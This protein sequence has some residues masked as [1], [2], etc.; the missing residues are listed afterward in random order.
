MKILLN[1]EKYINEAYGVFC[2]FVNQ[3]E[4]LYLPITKRAFESALKRQDSLFLAAEENGELIGF[5]L[6][7]VAEKGIYLTLIIVKHNHRNK[8]TGKA[9]VLKLE[10]L[11]KE[12][13]FDTLLIDHMNPAELG[14]R[15]PESRRTHNKIPGVYN[16]SQALRFFKSSG[17]CATHE[18]T[19]MYRELDGFTMPDE[20]FSVI[21]SLERE[22]IE[23]GELKNFDVEFNRLCDNVKSEYWRN[24]IAS[25]I[26]AHKENRGN[27]D[28]RF[29]ADG[30]PPKKPRK[31][32]AA[33]YEGRM[34][35]FTG[36]VDLQKDKRGW[37]TGLCVDPGFGRRRIGEALFNLL[38]DAFKNE[39]AEFVS[40]YTGSNNP[41]KKIYLR[42][43]LKPAAQ[44]VAMKKN[45][46]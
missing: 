39:N 23:V 33:V 44:F 42:A 16:K 37:F 32:L 43:G 26:R 25:E 15:I 22:G 29:F 10:S 18:E 27:S 19:A 35:G 4:A 17:F 21:A 31:I 20:I 14:W 6:A 38:L 12:K 34:V 1:E 41:A 11:A 2:D 24:S 45:L 8:G 28:P 7:N 3:K 36:P 5:V 40:L 13:G 9:L 46:K 30:T